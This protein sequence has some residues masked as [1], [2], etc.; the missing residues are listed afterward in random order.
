MTSSN[1]AHI[2]LPGYHQCQVAAARRTKG[3]PRE[4]RA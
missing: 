2:P 4:D 1:A 3:R